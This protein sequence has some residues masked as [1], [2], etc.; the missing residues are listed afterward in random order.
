MIDW[1]KRAGRL[2]FQEAEELHED[3]VVTFCNLALFWNSQGSWRIAL[4]HKGMFE[5]HN[6]PH[7]TNHQYKAML[8]QL[9]H[10]IG[11]GSKTL[12]HETS[13]QAEVRRRRFWACYLTHCHLGEMTQPFEPWVMKEMALPWPETDFKRQALTVPQAYLEDSE[14]SSGSVFEELAR[15]LTIWT[16]VVSLVKLGP[17]GFD[18]R[19]SATHSLDDRLNKWWTRLPDALRVDTVSTQLVCD[20]NLGKTV[21]LNVLYHQSKCALHSSVV[22]L[23]SWSKQESGFSTAIQVSAQ[24][25]YEHATAVSELLNLVL[26][27]Q[28]RLSTIPSFVSYAA[29][30][31]TAIQIPFMTSTDPIVRERAQNNFRV[32]RKVHRRNGGV[33]EDRGTFGRYTVCL[34][35]RLLS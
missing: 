7:P 32:N 10:T 11:L 26:A 5:G 14:P 15:V 24:V 25:A 8:C 4:L 13:F 16:S 2:V 12:R 29:Y 31:G 22:P 20:D 34:H 3:N 21:L 27:N 28:R 9:L 19:L 30:C 6:S 17:P 1:A 23:F 35:V 18:E 33:L